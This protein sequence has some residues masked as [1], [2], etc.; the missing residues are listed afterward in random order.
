MR[1]SSSLLTT[2]WMRRRTADCIDINTG[3]CYSMVEVEVKIKYG[4]YYVNGTPA[5]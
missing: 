4:I 1:I 5:Q 2:K 3:K